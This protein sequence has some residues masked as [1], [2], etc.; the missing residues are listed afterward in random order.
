MQPLTCSILVQERVLAYQDHILLRLK[1]C[2]ESMMNTSKYCY[3]VNN[4]LGP[5]SPASLPAVVLTVKPLILLYC[6]PST[7]ARRAR[8]ED[9]SS[10]VIT[11]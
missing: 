2:A 3:A 5:S 10:L 8:P 1:R 9:R 6:I 11:R 4:V 7:R